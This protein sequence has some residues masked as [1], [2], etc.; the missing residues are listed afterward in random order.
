V[1]LGRAERSDSDVLVA[2]IGN[3]DDDVG[4]LGLNIGVRWFDAAALGVVGQQPVHDRRVRGIE[5]AFESLQP[6]AFLDDLGDVPMR[7]RHL[8]PGKFRSGRHALGWSQIGP[9]DPAQLDR[10]I[11]GDVDLMPELVLDGLVE[12]VDAS[13]G[14]IELPTVVHAAESTFFVAA[15]EQRG[16]AVW[17]KFVQEPDPALGVAEGDEV[18]AQEP[19]AHRRVV[20][21][22]DLARQQRRDPVSSHRVAHR[23]ALSH[24]G[25]QLVFLARQHSRSS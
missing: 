2:V 16:A 15:E 7:L 13:A 21:F 20:G 17:T 22:A 3:V 14:D 5:T 18:L 19:H 1:H 12:L 8:G 6:V 11:G 4:R 25:D 9:H 23:T 24:P 10:R